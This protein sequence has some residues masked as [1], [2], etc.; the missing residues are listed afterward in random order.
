MQ[1]CF[2][3]DTLFNIVQLNI[4]GGLVEY[5]AK[6]HFNLNELVLSSVALQ[7]SLTDNMESVIK[8]IHRQQQYVPSPCIT[9]VQT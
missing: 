3:L 5:S 4:R 7:N 2:G 6:Q 9:K 8:F 1:K